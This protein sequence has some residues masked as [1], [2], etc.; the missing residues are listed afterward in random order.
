MM[1]LLIDAICVTR[2]QS[3][4][5]PSLWSMEWKTSGWHCWIYRTK[6]KVIR[7]VLIVII[8]RINDDV[9][10]R[11]HFQPYWPFVW[12]IYRSPVNSPVKGQ[13]HW[14]WMFSL[15]CAW[16]NDWVNNREAG[17]LRRHRAHYDVTVL[18]PQNLHYVLTCLVCSGYRYQFLCN[19]CEL[20]DI[21]THI[22]SVFYPSSLRAGALLS[23]RFRAGGRA[24]GCQTCGTH[25][26]S[27][28][29]WANMGPIWGRQDLGGPHIG[30]MNFVI[31][32]HL[33]KRLTDFLCSK[34]CGIV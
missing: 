34:F 19:T 21:V 13:W 1:T 22:F 26:D 11:K 9:I 29:H 24:G 15:I 5:R 30:P 16:L 4:V 3:V 10:K 7:D 33:C 28:V 23:S 25:R 27:K 14:A 6:F 17:D 2:A 20:C 18:V 8:C 31:W 32:A 12:G